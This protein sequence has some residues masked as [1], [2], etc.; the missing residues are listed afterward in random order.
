MFI[1]KNSGNKYSGLKNAFS[2]MMNMFNKMST[3]I[4]KNLTININDNE[5]NNLVLLFQRVQMGD[6][7]FMNRI[8]TMAQFLS[9]QPE[10]RQ[11]LVNY[12]KNQNEKRPTIHLNLDSFYSIKEF[13]GVI[14][15]SCVKAEDEYTG[16]CIIRYS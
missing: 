8:I 5:Q 12:L 14:L 10:K 7:R 1:A 6:H 9:T 3:E 13:L 2:G 16:L 4:N 15:Q 11:N